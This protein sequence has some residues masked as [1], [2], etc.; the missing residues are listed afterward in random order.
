[1]ADMSAQL[2][3]VPGLGAQKGSCGH[4]LSTPTGQ[5]AEAV[6]LSAGHFTSFVGRCLVESRIE[7]EWNSDAPQEEMAV[8]Q[9][10]RECFFGQGVVGLCGQ[11]EHAAIMQHRF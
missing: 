2:G 8:M 7:L 3:E 6:W 10:S 9:M 11:L 4:V 1:M 5:A